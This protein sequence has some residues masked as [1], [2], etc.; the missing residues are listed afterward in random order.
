M[1]NTL[2]LPTLFNQRIFRIPDY[3]RGYAWEKEQVGELLE[4]LW[5]LNAPRRHYAG[6]IVLCQLP[7][8]PVEMGSDGTTYATHAVVDGQQRLTTIVLLLNELSRALEAYPDFADL[9]QGIRK[10]YVETKS[11]DKWSIYKLSLNGKADDF[12]KASIL[13]ETPRVEEP[14]LRAAARLRD[15]KKQIADYLRRGDESEEEHRQLL[16]AWHGKLTQLLHFNLYEVE[17]EAEV[18]IIFEVMNDRGKPLTE[19]EKVKNYLLYAS[20]SLD[21]AESASDGLGDAVNRAWGVILENLMAAGLGSRGYEDQLLQMHWIKQYDPQAKN[22]D[23]VKSVKGKFGLRR[24]AGRHADLLIALR[25]Y[26]EDLRD[27]SAAFCDARNPRWAGAFG[28]FPDGVRNDLRYWSAKLTRIGVI[29]AFL[30]LLIATRQRWPSDPQKYVELVEL[31]EAFAF[32]IY[33][34]WGAKSNYR[35]SAMFHLAYE[36]A[37]GMEFGE[38]VLEIKRAYGSREA[39]RYFGEFTNAPDP[40]PDYGYGWSGLGYFLYEYEEDLAEA[41]GASPEISFSEIAKAGLKDSIEHVLPQYIGDRPYWQERFTASEHEE[42][43]HD[44]GNLALT[45]WNPHFS[46]KPFPEKKGEFGARTENG[47]LTRCYANSLLCQEQELALQDD[48]TKESI[49]ARR[50]KLLAW[51]AERWRVDFSDLDGA[52]AQDVEPDEDQ[53]NDEVDEAEEGAGAS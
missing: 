30:P 48:W 31:C 25:E 17:K 10:N 12:F 41:K 5:L 33:R 47:E 44:V 46:N 6:T 39:R 15:A 43:V 9:A 4:D 51:A 16:T 49:N 22:W 37:H 38:A 50:A 24:Y 7:D 14:Q 2:S 26:V 45:K 32:R 42:Y 1:D 13:P 29:R 11:L 19:L 21:V 34:I 23:G 40:S 53:P 28:A 52:G 20:R 36:V 3:Q 18:G 27:S 8:A 35:E